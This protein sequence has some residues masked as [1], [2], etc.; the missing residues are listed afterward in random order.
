MPLGAFR[1]N[2]IAKRFAVTA[3]AEVIRAKKGITAVGNA[4]ISTAQSKFGGAS[5]LFDGT[6]DY[7]TTTDLS[8]G[9]GAFTIEFFIR[10][11]TLPAARAGTSWQMAWTGASAE[12]Y[13][14]VWSNNIQVA[15]GNTYGGFSISTMS[16]NTWYH[17]ALV[18][19]GGDYK[20]FFNGTDCGAASDDGGG[21]QSWTNRSGTRDWTGTTTQ[22]IASFSANTGKGIIGYM[23]EI[24]V[25]NSARYTSNFTP[26]TVPFT[27]D[28]N[29]L[30]LI[31]ANGTN[32]STFFEDDNGVRA[33]RGVTAQNGVVLSTVQS[34]FGSTSALFNG[35]NDIQL[36]AHNVPPITGNWTVEFWF[37]PNNGTY[38]VFS[39]RVNAG[40]FGNDEIFCYYIG[41]S[42]RLE[43]NYRPNS[44]DSI[45]ASNTSMPHSNWYHCAWVKN[46]TTI[47]F[48][49]NGTLQT[50]NKTNITANLGNANRTTWYFGSIDGASDEYNGYLD[51]IR[52]SDTA[53]YTT[54]FTPATAPFVNDANTQLLIHCDGTNASTVFRDDNGI[55]GKNITAFGNAQIS[56]AQSKFGGSSAVFDGTGDYLTV[57]P[58]T[59]FYFTS[60]SSFTVEC[61]LRTTATNNNAVICATYSLSSPFNGWA[62]KIESN[63]NR[64]AFWDGVS[65][66]QFNIN[67]IITNT[68]HHAAVVSNNG[69]CKMYIDGVEQ[70]TT[71]T[72]TNSI[73]NNTNFLHI[74]SNVGGS[75]SFTGHLDELRISNTARYTANFTP[76]TAPFV[77][78]A[79]TLLLLHMDGAN[80]STAFIDSA[81]RSQT[82]VQAT[83]NAMVSTAQSKFGG[84]S[85]RLLFSN[86]V[87][88]YLEIKQSSSL[89]NFGTADWTVEGWFRFDNTNTDLAIW[90][91]GTT[92]GDIDIRR[93]NDNLLRIGRINVAWD[94][95]SGATGILA[96]TWYHLAFVKGSG[97]LRIYVNGTQV[98]SASNN[99]S[100]SI[101]TQLRIGAQSVS[102]LG[103]SGYIDDLRAS[104]IARYTD[105]FTAP[106][107]PF[108]N[109]RNTLLLLHMDGTN[110]S[111]VFIDDNGQ[112]PFTPT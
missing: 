66:R 12:D 112:I 97:T 47:N 19:S 80:A 28:E 92:N 83:T 25:S 18:R 38:A 94:L 91:G 3:V 72:L 56:T 26:T 105:N 40:N 4:Q 29:T 87:W 15:V 13:I 30:L 109:D 1:I 96:N 51:E 73:L 31:H 64:L 77:N 48:Y 39:N 42:N 67:T 9:S 103:M 58:S 70:T 14:L 65:W 44:N 32:A 98:G 5:A 16:A 74:G 11:T 20:V 89:L 90:T 10:F 36:R 101:T 76:S 7:L 99:I 104:D 107:E 34:Q 79:N 68:W 60:D 24:R 82:G 84:A 88:N 49:I 100:Y 63:N 57:T 8:V 43:W 54:G 50:G 21:A 106:T 35:T 23:D 55:I 86:S 108:V 78:D 33:Q 6:G 53:R 110:N 27:N 41:S 17:I 93:T 46:G 95:I 85:L 61:W 52:I 102:S 22:F 75:N 69:S 111:T 2:S 71:F 81:S 62:F 37:R 59:S 45:V